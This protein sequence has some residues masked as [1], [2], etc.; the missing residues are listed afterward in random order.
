[1][2][3]VNNLLAIQYILAD[4]PWATTPQYLNSRVFFLDPNSAE[5]TI[6]IVKMP[7]GSP[8]EYV[9]FIEVGKNAVSLV[10]FL[11]T[12]DN[13]WFVFVTSIGGKQNMNAGNG[14]NSLLE[15]IHITFLRQLPNLAT[16]KTH[17]YGN[18]TDN[19]DFHGLT[20]NADG[21]D[22]YFLTANVYGY[23][24]Q[25]YKTQMVWQVFRTCL[26]T[27]IGV[28]NT[29][30]YDIAAGSTHALLHNAG[31]YSMGYLWALHYD[32]ANQLLWFAHGD[33]IKIYDPSIGFALSKY[34]FNMSE[35][36]P[37]SDGNLNSIELTAESNR[38]GH[39]VLLRGHQPHAVASKSMTWAEY[40]RSE[41]E[42]AR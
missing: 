21:S 18:A 39:S 29:E 12:S 5:P 10:P 3:R 24:S 25:T 19:L 38:L 34:S 37:D 1:M 31:P 16:R 41:I 15:S 17:Y 6:P 7:V 2:V 28:T 20:F 30:F 9:D 26:E 11:D 36:N 14:A 23:D 27:L 40:A 8:V 32:N 35:L 4:D 22:A 13:S 33:S 42:K